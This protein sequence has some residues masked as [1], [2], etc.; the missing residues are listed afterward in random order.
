MRHATPASGGGCRS[1]RSPDATPRGS[2]G[3]ARRGPR[4]GC[5]ARP[6]PQARCS[7]RRSP[8]AA[9]PPPAASRGGLPPRGAAPASSL[10]PPASRGPDGWRDCASAPPPTPPDPACR[11]PK[12]LQPPQQPP[13][14]PRQPAG[15]QKSRAAQ[16]AAR[17]RPARRWLVVLERALR[18]PYSW[19][20]ELEAQLRGWPANSATLGWAVAPSQRDSRRGGILAANEP[21][22]TRLK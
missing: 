7:L 5:A 20:S 13:S 16:R 6:G 18:R 19:R 21:G 14:V 11:Q 12:W 9:S 17:R 1:A 3:P 15:S 4:P 8:R 22:N 10:C 2:S